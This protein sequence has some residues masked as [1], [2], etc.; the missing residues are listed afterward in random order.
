MVLDKAD[1]KKED[2]L[3]SC[4]KPPFYGCKLTVKHKNRNFPSVYM[5]ELK[6]VTVFSLVNGFL[7]K[8]KWS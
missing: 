8:E 1:V 6:E 7:G 4:C 3:V 5:L 2:F